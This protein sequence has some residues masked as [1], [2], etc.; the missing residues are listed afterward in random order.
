MT[1]TLPALND[2]VLPLVGYVWAATNAHDPGGNST[3]RQSGPERITACG[4]GFVGSEY[5]LVYI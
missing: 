5:S 3:G 2:L 4:A 1:E